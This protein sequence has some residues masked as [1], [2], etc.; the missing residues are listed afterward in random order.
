MGSESAVPAPGALPVG[1]RA[2]AGRDGAGAGGLDPMLRRRVALK[3]LHHSDPEQLVSIIR[4]AQNQARL[5]HPNI[6]RVLEVEAGGGNPSSP[7]RSL[8]G[9]PWGI[10]GRN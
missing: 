2:R 3:L 5:D 6:C 4:G 10:C 8:K 9:K 7:W 1:A